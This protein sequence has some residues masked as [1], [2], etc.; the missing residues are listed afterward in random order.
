MVVGRGAGAKTIDLILAMW[1]IEALMRQ[2]RSAD[3]ITCENEARDRIE[4]TDLRVISV[5]KGGR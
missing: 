4:D 2:P 1:S 5:Y 3:S